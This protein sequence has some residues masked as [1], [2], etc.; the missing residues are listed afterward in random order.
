MSVRA[1]GSKLLAISKELNNQWHYTRDYWRDAKSLEFQHKYIEEL[2]SGV[3]RAVAVI[4]Q[5]DKIVT[6]IRNDCE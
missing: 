6:K 3:D 1:N 5:L 2:M 4:E